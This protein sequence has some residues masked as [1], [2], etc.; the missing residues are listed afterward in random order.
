MLPFSKTRGCWS[1]GL[2][3]ATQQL[4]VTSNKRRTEKHLRTHSNPMKPIKLSTVLLLLALGSA[5]A[6]RA[7]WTAADVGAPAHPG[8]STVNGDGT[9]TIIGS[10]HD[11]WDNSD[12]FQ[13]Y[14]QSVSGQYWEASYRCRSL[15]GP[16]LWSKSELMV[17][18]PTGPTPTGPDSFYAIMTTP[19]PLLNLAGVGGQNEIQPQWR[20][21]AA[22]GPGNQAAIGGP[23][24]PNYPN[25]WMKLSRA[26]S[27]FYIYWSHDGTTWTLADSWNTADGSR[28]NTA[29]AWEDPVFV[30][31]AV[32]AHDQGAVLGTNV[33]SDLVLT[34]FPIIPPTAT[35]KTLD[36]PAAKTVFSGSEASF[37]F[38]ATNNGSPTIAFPESYQWYKNGSAVAGVTGTA[39]TWLAQ[40][41][42]NGAQIYAVGY[43]PGYPSISVTSTVATLTV[44]SASLVF[45][46][47]V[48]LEVFGGNNS[49]RNDAEIGNTGSGDTG[50]GAI[51]GKL[52]WFTSFEDGG[53]YGDNTSRRY[54]GYFIPWAT[55]NYTFYV[56]ADD[57]SDLF[58]STDSTPANKQLI[59]QEP[60]WSGFNNW[61]N[62][63][64]GGDMAILQKSSD[65]WTNAAGV[66]NNPTG[67][68]LNA[69]S[70]YY[71]E[72]VE[73][74]GGGGDNASVT[75][76]IT[77]TPGPANGSASTLNSATS[78]NLALIT[79]QAT[80]LAFSGA[81]SLFPTNVTVSEGQ[82]ANFYARANTDSEFAPHYQ[83]QRY[84]TNVPG[85]TGSVYTLNP[86]LGSQNGMPVRVVATVPGLAPVTSSVGT[87]T[88]NTAVFEPGFVIEEKWNVNNLNGAIAGTLGTPNYVAAIP[89]L[90][91]SINNETGDNYTRRVS[92]FLIPATTGA[93]DFYTCS[94]DNS[95]LFLSSN[96]DP[97][98]A[99]EIA[100]DN[101]WDNPFNWTASDGGANIGQKDSATWTNGLGVAPNAAGVSLAAGTKYY[102]ASYHQEGGG[103]DNVTTAMVPHGTTPVN[104]QDYAP[105]GT[106]IGINAPKANFV[107]FTVQPTNPPA[108][109]P[110]PNSSANF[111]AFGVTDSLIAVGS[112]RANGPN[113]T[114]VA[115][116]FV[117]FQWF[118]NGV[119]I[120]G[121]TGSLYTKTGLRNTDNA[122]QYMCQMRALGYGIAPNTRFWSNSLTATLTVTND[123]TVPTISYSGYYLGTEPFGQT[124]WVSVTFSIPMDPTTLSNPGNYTVS[125]GST[126]YAV[127]VSADGRRVQLA[128]DILPTGTPIVTITGAKTWACVALSANT[129][130][131]HAL[132]SNLTFHDIGR[133]DP[134]TF[135]QDPTWPSRLYIDGPNAYTIAAQGSDIWD[136]HDGFNFLYETKNGD[137]DVVMRQTAYSLTDRWAKVG[138]MAREL[139]DDYLVPFAGGCRDWNIVNDPPNLPCLADGN[140]ANA[141]EC[142][143]RTNNNATGVIATSQ[144][145][146]G[147]IGA[148][149][150]Y[151]NAWVRLKR[152]GTIMHAF[153]GSNGLDWTELATMDVSLNTWNPTIPSTLYVGICVTGHHNDAALAATPQFY[154]YGTVDNYNSS[155]VAPPPHPV[156]TAT[157]SGANVVI[158]WTGTV[159]I[160]QQSTDLVTW[161]DVGS[162]NPTT[163]PASGPAKFFKV[164]IP[165]P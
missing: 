101:G 14:Y 28:G 121:A 127:Q 120:P 125:G 30:G 90:E 2:L 163:V 52:R 103:G 62:A 86:T 154:N 67:I 126:V 55:G 65:T 94:D 119:A 165:F 74:N 123:P 10:G 19:D 108:V 104:G 64:G 7:A 95:V 156:L 93:Y 61:T 129:I 21:L 5:T 82:P 23:I 122:S 139:I 27:W 73:H 134:V 96:S 97:A 35:G 143:W 140:G 37:S 33:I 116:Q 41:A 88:V 68:A 56:G 92:G 38:T 18:R 63:G 162:A 53:G 135:V 109:G 31:V 84:G 114:E 77:G 24:T 69:G 87:L 72:L 48:K 76:Q 85:A 144:G 12:D 32:T 102:I 54:S 136:T 155:Y 40:P 15:V 26:G 71:I 107:A 22:G 13:F 111:Y 118:R 81:G 11:I 8:S 158:S 117:F 152:T 3:G 47:G 80:T 157:P 66:T 58:L 51:A 133:Q 112:T 159:G 137:F 42:D 106:L 49:S 43:P 130:T 89:A 147:A 1:G 20:G 70:S 146:P 149:P 151:P 44:N 83:W 115:N 110:G 4:C 153:A 16:S 128:V 164:R 98:N 36:L 138:L 99:V 124:N 161:T 46:N 132:P 59:A 160:L 105:S 6:V 29:G 145:W 60:Q 113:N 17:R 148:A 150:S 78:N 79:W 25:T 75:A 91:A 131:S 39:F 45:T 57:D 34:V 9:I 100:R 141:V 142:N 50:N